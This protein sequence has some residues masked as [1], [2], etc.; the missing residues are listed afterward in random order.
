[1]P[2][3]HILKAKLHPPYLPTDFVERKGVNQ[4]LIHREENS[5][6]LFSAPSGYGKSTSVVSWLKTIGAD[7]S[8]LSLDPKDN[9]FKTF[10][11]YFVHAIRSQVPNF[12]LEIE[13]IVTS[14]PNLGIRDCQILLNNEVRDLSKE[15][16]L[17]LDDY[18]FI[19][20]SEIHEVLIHLYK[21][22]QPKLKLVIVA[23]KD[24]PFPLSSWRMKN[25]ITEIRESELTFNYDE[26][27]QFL[28]NQ[29]LDSP[30]KDFVEDIKKLTEGW[31]TG[32]RLLV[33]SRIRGNN[34]HSLTSDSSL[35]S[36][37]VLKE[38][39]HDMLQKQRPGI[40]DAI[41]KL[42]MADE[43]NEELYYRIL[44][45]EKERLKHQREFEGFVELLLR[46][47][48]FL[49][50][51]DDKHNWFRFHHLFQDIL[52][53]IFLDEYPED[54][55]RSVYGALAD[56]YK[57]DEQIEKCLELLLRLDRKAE[58]LSVFRAYRGFI[59]ERSEWQLL[60]R[61]L[62]LFKKHKLEDS[63]VLNLTH[64]WL[65]VY[66]GDISKMMKSLPQLERQ[67]LEAGLM[68]GE[69]GHF[70]GEINVLKAYARY[71]FEI[72]MMV[73]LDC[74]STALALLTKDNLYATG[75]AWVFYGGALQALGKSKL[76]QREI[77]QRIDGSENS[78]VTSNLY[79]ILCYIHWMD[80][81]IHELSAVAKAL[82]HLGRSDDLKEAEAN[83]YYFLGC[84]H[85]SLNKREDALFEFKKLYA[86][87]HYTL[88]VHRFFGS[89]ALAFLL[90][91]KDEESLSDLLMEMRLNAMEGGGIHYVGF[92]QAISATVD[93][94]RM[95]DSRSLNWALEADH[96]P[97]LPMSNFTS[98]QMLQAYILASSG[99]KLHAK[100]ALEILVEC[101]NFLK[102]FNNHNFLVQANVLSAM[103]LSV[104]ERKE[105][106]LNDFT[107]A[108]ELAV[109]RGLCSAFLA[110]EYKAIK[111][112]IWS[113]NLSTEEQRFLEEIKLQI[114]PKQQRMN[115]SLSRR[116][117][118]VLDQMVMSISNKQI[119]EN[120]Y[121][122][123]ATVKRHIANIYKKLEVHNRKEAIE[124][125][126]LQ[127]MI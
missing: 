39:I 76:A 48:L 84:A 72:D 61:L 117:Q 27:Y 83:G 52:K 69:Q 10:I 126:R 1:M 101:K 55:I 42:S 125:G 12:G 87:K 29:R 33:A 100:K 25:R 17:V 2:N 74:A 120:L 113:L 65:N 14:S 67:C 97:I 94:I 13:Q 60:E 8:W 106:A 4:R 7:F 121:I 63:F 5:I 91:E 85:F 107:T 116:E 53:Q 40:R 66:K 119:A 122:S 3:N 86:L 34:G 59:F 46:S 20:N 73:C 82:I 71:N 24:P 54:E 105:E 99:V 88:M 56:W 45:V 64:A 22:S 15:V 57:N 103:S 95:R 44:S 127:K 92:V 96:H 112:F 93:W 108:L 102:K 38:L 47:N 70:L 50:S 28:S 89:A 104:L 114:S 23:R 49:I 58:A 18:H 109:P 6:F 43:F 36:L 81:N 111:D 123:L 62:L 51:L 80:G 30:E 32:L 19:R 37:E 77:I 75:L 68:R 98:N 31:I 16:Y 41:V 124:K 9:E 118:Q 79:L 78:I 35:K 21:F 110:L 26:T 115:S 11:S 90:I